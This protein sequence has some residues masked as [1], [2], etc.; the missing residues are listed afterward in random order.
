MPRR[1]A[2][3]LPI[4]SGEKRALV[5][6]CLVI[7]ALAG[8]TFYWLTLAPP[9][10][11]ASYVINV[12]EW[13][14]H[15]KVL[16]DKHYPNPPPEDEWFT[17]IVPSGVWTKV[18][19]HHP[20]QYNL[21][22]AGHYFISA[23]LPGRVALST[24]GTDVEVGMIKLEQGQ[25]VRFGCGEY[26][27]PWHDYM[28]YA[29]M[30]AY[31]PKV[32]EVRLWAHQFYF[33]TSPEFVSDLAKQEDLRGRTLVQANLG[34]TIRLTV[35]M[36]NELEPEF[37]AMGIG[38]NEF[39]FEKEVPFGEEVVME[40]VAD[41]LGVFEMKCAVACGS[42]HELMKFKIEVRLPIVGK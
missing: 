38:S 20:E 36:T 8:Y 41:K 37:R 4:T 19:L 32:I 42:G 27:V 31:T 29:R 11:A 30:I 22:A 10:A 12:Y 35:R 39:G 15:A 9:V 6:T 26:C 2:E 5:G 7:I 17:V 33:S 1:E 25:V 23:S 34:D 24:P 28:S 3:Q 13:A 40:F 14:K 21:T 18:I 16:F